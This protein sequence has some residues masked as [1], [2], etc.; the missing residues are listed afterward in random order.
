MLGL[1]L[2]PDRWA[3]RF[4]FFGF[5]AGIVAGPLNAAI[6]YP[7]HSILLFCDRV[8]TGSF[9]QIMRASGRAGRISS[10]R[11]A[12]GTSDSTVN[13]VRGEVPEVEVRANPSSHRIPH[14]PPFTSSPPRILSSPAVLR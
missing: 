8:F 14:H 4:G 7:V 13:S 9:N 10:T 12:W 3:R 5:L 11:L 6:L 2:I 1:Y